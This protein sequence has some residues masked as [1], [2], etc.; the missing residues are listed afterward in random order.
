MRNVKRGEIFYADLS[1]VVG[2]EQDG[3]R[4]VLVIQN[5][6]GNKFSP[7]T[8]V[9]AITSKSEKAKLPTHVIVHAD[10]LEMESVVLL[11]Q[12]RTIDKRRLIR[13]SGKLS[14]TA[15]GRVDHAIIVSFGIKYMESCKQK[16]S[17]KIEE[18]E[19]FLEN[20]K[21]YTKPSL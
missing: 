17:P 11:E 3:T 18:I 16:S 14:K 12:I 2:S 4:P 19:N 6:T 21:V 5:D 15:M 1:P 10:G 7:T 9:A 20:E 13:Y 8:I